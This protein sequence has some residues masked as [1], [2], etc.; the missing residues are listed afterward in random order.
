MN[1]AL[2]YIIIG[3]ITLVLGLFAGMYI[4]KLKTKS[5]ES[6]WVDRNLK[7]ENQISELKG[8]LNNIREAKSSLEMLKY[9]WLEP[10]A[11]I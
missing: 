11:D 4:Q 9:V 1:E 2:I 8:E 5:S 7:A 6:V 3:L 10:I